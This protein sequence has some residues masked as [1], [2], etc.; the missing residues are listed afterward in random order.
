MA[1][2]ARVT[3]YTM[4]GAETLAE[5]IQRGML[6]GT[7]MKVCEQV[8][9]KSLE[10]QEENRKLRGENRKLK[11]MV[12]Q[13][14]R[15]RMELRQDRQEAF[16]MVLEKDAEHQRYKSWRAALYMG[17]FALGAVAV[18]IATTIAVLR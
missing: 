16:R 15:D 5:A 8:A 3:R 2:M 7:A 11:E 1:E 6:D 14:R 12:K 4:N 17:L 10:L 18:A 13:S 9:A